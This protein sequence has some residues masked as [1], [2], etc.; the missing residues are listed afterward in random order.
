MGSAHIQGSRTSLKTT[1]EFVIKIRRRFATCSRVLPAMHEGH[2]TRH[3]SPHVTVVNKI[4][5]TADRAHRPIHRC[6]VA[7]RAATSNARQPA[8]SVTSRA[9]NCPD[10]WDVV[11]AH[12]QR[13]SN[14]TVPPSLAATVLFLLLYCFT[15]LFVRDTSAR[16]FSLARR[17]FRNM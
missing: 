13:F 4:Q 8:R 10:S 12:Y 6:V 11:S 1:Q 15:I 3:R 9:T 2:H 14:L 17:S 5:H 7:E 16:W